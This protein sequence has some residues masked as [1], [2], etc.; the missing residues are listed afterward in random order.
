MQIKF[1]EGDDLN[2]IV[3][4]FYNELAPA[5][6]LGPNYV[7]QDALAPKRHEY[8]GPAPHVVDYE[9]SGN[10]RD[11]YVEWWD[12]YLNEKW[13]G[14]RHW[15]NE[16]YFESTIHGWVLKPRGRFTVLLDDGYYCGCS[17]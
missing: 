5:G 3:F 16:A 13:V 17:E 12:S 4:E 7:N 11:C 6:Y 10:S 8:L 2:H 14:N 1:Q 15:A 9:F